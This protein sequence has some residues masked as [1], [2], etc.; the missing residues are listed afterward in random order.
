MGFFDWLESDQQEQERH[1]A[2]DD[3]GRHDARHEGFVGEV[4]HDLGDAVT[5]IVP[6]TTEHQSYEQGYHDQ[7]SGRVR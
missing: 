4:F 1:E 6:E 3:R 5:T 2:S 7:R